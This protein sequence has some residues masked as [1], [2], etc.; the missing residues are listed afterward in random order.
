MTTKHKF[1]TGFSNVTTLEYQ[2]KTLVFYYTYF[3]PHC[4]PVRGRK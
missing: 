1:K 3:T 2:K 4:T